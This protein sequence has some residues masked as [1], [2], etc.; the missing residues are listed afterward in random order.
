MWNALRAPWLS[1]ILA[2]VCVCVRSHK[3]PRITHVYNAERERV[4]IY[5]YMFIYTTG[6]EDTENQ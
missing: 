4:Y 3:E 5:I 1:E 2:R 6:P